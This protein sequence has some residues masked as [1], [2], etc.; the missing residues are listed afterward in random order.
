VVVC[1][2]NRDQ[3]K[4]AQASLKGLLVIRTDVL[5]HLPS[6]PVSRIDDLLPDRWH[7][8]LRDKAPIL[9]EITEER[10]RG[11]PES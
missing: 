9:F 6:Q 5:W 2:R 11:L 3:L 1:T 7:Y 8:V 4:A 10:V